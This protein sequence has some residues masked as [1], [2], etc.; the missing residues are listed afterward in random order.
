MTKL[1]EQQT[2]KTWTPGSKRRSNR[3]KLWYKKLK[4]F[5]ERTREK[6]LERER[7]REKRGRERKKE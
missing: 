2:E 1:T 5:Q 7:E 4:Q 6:K 3:T